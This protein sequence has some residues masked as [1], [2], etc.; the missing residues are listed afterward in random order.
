VLRL[1][2]AEF[3][4][5]RNPALAVGE[6]SSLRAQLVSDRWLAEL[7]QRLELNSLIHKGSSAIS[8]RAAQATIGAECCEAL[9]G[10]IY[11]CW[12]GSQGGLDAVRRW[13]DP[14][15]QRSCLELE[16]DPHLH[17]W[18][19]ALQEWSQAT[20]GELP[21]YQNEERN[22][23]HGNP[24]RFISRVFFAQKQYGQG[25]GPSRRD[26]EQQAAKA[27]LAKIKSQPQ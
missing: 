21:R 23:S 9:V 10:A 27:A 19:S 2:C 20:L 6:R 14:H 1:V 16:A 25:A 17:N 4:E 15:W 24:E 12:G 22:R 7:A 3:L 5:D 8:D 26:A 13:L 18:K 11:V